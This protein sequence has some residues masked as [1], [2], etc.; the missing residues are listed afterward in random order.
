M[1]AV[2]PALFL[3]DY[4]LPAMTALELYDRLH[5]I[6]VFKHVPALII[7][8]SQPSSMRDEIAKRGLTFLEK[9]FA[10]ETLSTTIK[11]ILDTPSA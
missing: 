6:E 9:P 7:S 4:H 8:A 11:H 5:K 1:K 10:V 2:K 3:L